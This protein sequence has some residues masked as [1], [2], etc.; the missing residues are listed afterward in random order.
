MRSVLSTDDDP[1][2]PAGGHRLL[3]EL[4]LNQPRA[5]RVPALCS[6]AF[7]LLRHGRIAHD[8]APPSARGEHATPEH[9]HTHAHP[10]PTPPPTAPTIS[11]EVNL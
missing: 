10:G 6:D 1:D 11:V 5:G 4:G 7:T 8:G 9:D 2:C 3:T